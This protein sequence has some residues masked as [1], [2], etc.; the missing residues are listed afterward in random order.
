MVTAETPR[1]RMETPPA[2]L[3]Q[4]WLVANREQPTAVQPQRSAHHALPLPG[5]SHPHAMANNGIGN[6]RP[7]PNGTCVEPGAGT[8]RMPGS[9]ARPGKTHQ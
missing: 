8:T 5:N 7:G 4:P 1:N 3:L 9:G 6:P 2:L